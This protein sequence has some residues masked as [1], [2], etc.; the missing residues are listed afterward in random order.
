M[1]K[2]LLPL[3]ALFLAAPLAAQDPPLDPRCP[4]G[5]LAGT[6]GPGSV[7][8]GRLTDDYAFSVVYPREAA[9]NPRLDA[10]LRDEALRAEVRFE[11]TV[12]E[13][14]DQEGRG[15]GRL[16][17]EQVWHVDALLPE[18]IALSSTTGVYTGGAHG[19]I[20]YR[21]ILFDRR[22]NRQ[23]ALADVFTVGA[24]EYD[25]LGARPVGEGAMRRS[26]C[27]ALR[28]D[29]RERRANP[30]ERIECPDIRQLPITLICGPNNRIEAMRALVAP[31]IVGAWAEGPY[32][33]DFP[34]D[35]LMMAAVRR[36]FRPAFAVPG[37]NRPRRLAEPC[38]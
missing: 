13:F 20:Q 30:A 17:Y 15:A 28:A 12:A 9:A 11:A 34:I 8:I 4:Q 1:F 37:E 33:V 25:F 36:H 35:A 26:F 14:R 7:C 38:R 21:T 2:A 24:F 22:R 10:L 32:E 19:G 3:A 16:S 23:I 18:L 6:R 31:Y 29:V 27:R 5:D